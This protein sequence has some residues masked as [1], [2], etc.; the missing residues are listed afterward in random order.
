MLLT[1]NASIKGSHYASALRSQQNLISIQK[2]NLLVSVLNPR[3][4]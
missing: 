3:T 1:K 2:R 4:G